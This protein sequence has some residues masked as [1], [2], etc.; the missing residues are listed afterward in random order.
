VLRT[1]TIVISQTPTVALGVFAAPRAAGL[2]A[3]A[4]RLAEIVLFLVLKPLR[5][6]AQSAVAAL[7]R[8]QG[9]TAPFFLDLVELAGFGAFTAFAGLALVADPLTVVLLGEDWRE[10]SAILPFL[11]IAGSVTALAAIQEAYLLAVDRMDTFL[12]ATLVEALVGVVIVGLAS[13]FGPAAA[14][15]GVAARALLALPLRTSAALSP[16]GIPVM[17]LVRALASP[18]V[19]TVGM[20]IAVASWRIAVLGRIADVLFVVSA[21]AL[22]VA[23]CGGLLFGLMPET[24]ARL[25]TF[26][27]KDDVHDHR[28][29][30]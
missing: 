20:F 25:R 4:Q 7:R 1:L 17:R 26:V 28:A 3:F 15:A 27:R 16:E 24:V 6:V 8:Q 11:C 12:S 21:V 23:V 14:A 29:P 5:G 10:A 9:S 18:L 19:L 13:R 2:Y 22:G 30:S